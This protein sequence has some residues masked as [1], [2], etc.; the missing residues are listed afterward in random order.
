M[1]DFFERLFDSDFTPYGQAYLGHPEV[2]WVHVASDALIALAFF[3]ILIA[4]AYFLRNRVG[5]S[6]RETFLLFGLFVFACGVIHLMEIWS[7]WNGTFRFFGIVKAVTGVAGIAAA[8]VLLKVIPQALRLPTPEELQEASLMVE[9]EK[10]DRQRE[11]SSWSAERDELKGQV[12]ARAREFQTASAS[13]TAE[14]TAAN[15]LHELQLR[16]FGPTELRPLCNEVV[17]GMIELHK[18]DMGSLQLYHAESG[19]L[20]VLAH[21]GFESDVSEKLKDVSTGSPLWIATLR[22]GDSVV[23]EDV[24]AD[25]AFEPHWPVAASAGFRAMQFT[26]LISQD[27]ELI[28]LVSTHFR[29]AGKPNE[30]DTKYARLYAEQAAHMI[31]RQRALIA[32]TE[33][34]LR[35][36]Q[37]IGG[38]NEAGIFMLDPA[39]KVVSWNQGAE[40]I[41]GLEAPEILGKHFSI[42]FEPEEL[43]A[44]KPG[45]AMR[46]AVAE[47]RFEDQVTRLRKDGVRYWSN[48]VLTP[49]KNDAGDLQGFAGVMRD[50]TEQKRT[51]DELRLSEAYLAE[52]EKVSH[53]GSWGWNVLSGEVYWSKETFRIFGVNPGDMKPS[54]QLFLQFVHPEDRADLEQTL[55]KAKSEKSDFKIEFRIV[56]ADGSTRH[57]RSVGHPVLEES[58]LAEFAGA[59]I[60][61]TDQK[62]SEKVFR[63]VQ[64]E[65]ARVARLTIEEYASSI[66]KEIDESLDAISKN[67]DFCFRLAEAT[68]A[69]PLSRASLS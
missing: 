30:R 59:I 54:Y 19:A 50:V 44:E 35:L 24:L 43:E 65:F 11:R 45:E 27:K 34:D 31:D 5:L 38:L 56:L 28:G 68:R 52:A 32:Q 41:A 3:L 47:G 15:R 51:E 2:L 67:G 14:Q 26:P 7:V 16:L 58:L 36:R 17:T 46:R 13:L 63:N 60:D 1:T 23:V 6:R 18:A 12:D 9:T 40:R 39:G 10:A 53:T 22:R 62:V 48:I 8:I 64:A 20:E 42:L 37:L 55:E 33:R 57:L 66:A 61:I 25:A 4:L 29:Q 49:L 69:L 21:H